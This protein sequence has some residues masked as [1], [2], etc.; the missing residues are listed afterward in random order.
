MIEDDE[1]EA[2]LKII[3]AKIMPER[4]NI[5]ITT[6]LLVYLARPIQE[7]AFQ[8]RA[9]IFVLIGKIMKN[10]KKGRKKSALWF[11]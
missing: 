2:T 9:R 4:I 3:N 11:F 1:Y 6:R 8:G 5:T 7:I 10:I